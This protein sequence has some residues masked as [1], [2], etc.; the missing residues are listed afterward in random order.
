MVGF[1]AGAVVVV[2]C[3][4]EPVVLVSWPTATVPSSSTAAGNTVHFEKLELMVNILL[5]SCST[6]LLGIRNTQF[7]RKSCGAETGRKYSPPVSPFPA[8]VLFGLN[9]SLASRGKFTK[10][11]VQ[12]KKPPIS[13]EPFATLSNRFRLP[14]YFFSSVGFSAGG[15]ACGGGGCGVVDVP[16]MPSLKLRMPSP[17]PFITSGMRRPPKNI[18]TMASTINQWKILNSPMDCLRVIELRALST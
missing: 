15:C 14:V 2:P 5:I 3:V 4:E 17:K 1:G 10:L 11:L 13:R 9:L 8:G 12:N 16:L 7:W 18:S 6:D